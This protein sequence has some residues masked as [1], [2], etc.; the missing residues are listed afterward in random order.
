MHW[1]FESRKRHPST[2]PDNTRREQPHHY[3][4]GRY[5]NADEL[6]FHAHT[7]AVSAMRMQEAQQCAV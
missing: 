7:Q 2:Y 1:H 3:N 4:T 5:D 6:I